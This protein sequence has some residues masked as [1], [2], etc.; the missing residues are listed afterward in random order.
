MLYSQFQRLSHACPQTWKKH[1][2]IKVRREGKGNVS[3]TFSTTQDCKVNLPQDTDWLQRHSNSSRGH[4]TI[5]Q[6]LIRN[7]WPC[8]TLL[9][10]VL[11]TWAGTCPAALWAVLTLRQ[12]AAHH[13]RRHRPARGHSAHAVCICT[14]TEHLKHKIKLLHVAVSDKVQHKLL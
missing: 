4:R 1:I 6:L 7:I 10:S 2:D 8:V 3:L 11:C 9:P 12:S 5:P 14:S 13:R